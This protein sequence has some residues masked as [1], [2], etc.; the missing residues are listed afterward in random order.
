MTPAFVAEYTSAFATCLKRVSKVLP[1]KRLKVCVG[2]DSRPSGTFFEAAVISGICAAGIDVVQLGIVTT[3]CVGIMTVHLGCAGGVVITAS[4]NPAEYNGIKLLLDNGIAPT[5]DIAEDIQKIYYNKDFD[6]VSSLDSG[7]GYYCN[8]ADEVHIERIRTIC[9][10]DRIAKRKFKVVL[11][12]VNGAGGRITKKLLEMLGC[13]VVGIGLEPTGVFEHAPEPIREN[14]AALCE[15]VKKHKADIGF[16]QDPD[17]DRL[18]IIDDNGQCLGEEYTLALAVEHALAKKRRNVVTNLSTSRMIDLIAQKYNCNVIRTPVDEVNVADAMIKNNCYIGGE[19]NGGV[20]DLRVGPVR[21][22]LV[23]VA[24]VLQLITE[25]S[26]SISNI[27]KTIPSFVIMKNKM[28]MDRANIPVILANAKSIF[29]EAR[30]NDQDGY[31]FDFDD[32]WVHLRASNTEPI[33]RYIV[34]ADNQKTIDKYVARLN[35]VLPGA[36]L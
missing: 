1:Q 15:S 10:P 5:K 19:G 11:D 14:L 33:I 34:E 7:Q 8:M 21:D 27:V 36:V 29:A 12:S 9:Q 16:A 32:A 28:Q 6:Y 26:C 35:K 31:R 22:S 30:F 24:L 4:H 13:E 17:A 18:A 2:R 23:A 20:I 25:R 3:P